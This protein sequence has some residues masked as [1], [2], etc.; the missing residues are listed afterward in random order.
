MDSIG[1]FIVWFLIIMACVK[2]CDYVENKTEIE[3]KCSTMV[4]PVGK[5]M[6]PITNCKKGE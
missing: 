4:V 5:T 2:Q 1:S 6:M 3:S